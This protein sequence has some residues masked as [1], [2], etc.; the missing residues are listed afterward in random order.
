MTAISTFAFQPRRLM[1]ASAAD[2]C[3]RLLCRPCERETCNIIRRSPARPH[4]SSGGRRRV[5]LG[6]ETEAAPVGI[7]WVHPEVLNERALDNKELTSRRE[8]ISARHATIGVGIGIV[9]V[10]K[11]HM[12]TTRSPTLAGYGPQ[13]GPGPGPH[14]STGS[15]PRGYPDC[16]RLECGRGRSVVGVRHI[17]LHTT[18]R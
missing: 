11:I 5:A 17:D 9:R 16:M 7:V 8:K 10:P 4:P 1:I 15:A 13:P 14:W 6:V 2:G 3:K 18:A 12:A